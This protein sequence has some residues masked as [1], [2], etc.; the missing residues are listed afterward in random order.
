MKP[1]NHRIE[2][3]TRGAVRRPLKFQSGLRC[4]SQLILRVRRM[5]VSAI[6]RPWRARLIVISGCAL[7]LLAAAV[8]ALCYATPVSYIYC[9]SREDSWLAAKTEAELDGRMWMFYTKR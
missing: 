3:M 4:S 1:T 8:V 7:V 6:K 2:P 9:L 5:S